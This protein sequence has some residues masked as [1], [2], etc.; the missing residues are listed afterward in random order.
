MK[1]GYIISLLLFIA[2]I[3]LII[4]QMWSSFF[5]Q[6]LFLKILFTLALLFIMVLLVTLVIRDY[7][8][9]REM[10]NSGYLD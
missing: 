5:E 8:Q 4:V 2:G 9:E 6:V 7:F 10:R 3:V 1:F